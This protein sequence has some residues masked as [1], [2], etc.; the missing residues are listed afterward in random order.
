M[1]RPAGKAIY[2]RTCATDAFQ[3]PNMAN[4]M[5]DQLKVKSVF[6]VDDTG[7]YGVGPGGCVPGAQQPSAAMKVMGRDR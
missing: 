5:A 3:G 7:A 4:F 6:V 1:Y 2:F